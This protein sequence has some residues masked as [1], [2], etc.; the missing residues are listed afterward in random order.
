MWRLVLLL[1][2]GFV[3]SLFFPGEIL[4]LY[5]ILGFIL[6]PVRHWKN[7][8]L[9]ILSFI[10]MLQPV[11]WIKV[12]CGWLS[13]D[14]APRQMIFSLGDV[15]PQLGGD[16]WWEMVK[17]NFTIG[18]LASLNWAWC[19]GRVFQTCALF[20]L[21]LWI[22]RMGYFDSS[23]ETALGRSR[24]FWTY[25]LCFSLPLAVAF[26]FVKAFVF[27]LVSQ[28]LMLDSL[29]TIL[30]SWY[31]FCFMLTM[32]SAFL[33]LYWMGKGK[34]QKILVPYG[35]MSLTDYIMQSVIGSFL[36]FG[37][38]L[39]LHQYCGT[40]VSLLVGI[41][42]FLLQLAFSHWWFRHFKRGPLETLW[43][44]LTWLGRTVR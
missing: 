43:H 17:M 8:S 23:S 33:L 1:G 12:V 40:T 26:Y 42:F 34:I 7:R 3:N 30:N 36:Y 19:Y 39:A 24:S 25:V 11:E 18:Q 22:G 27:A 41:V 29:K 28:P 14:Y 6:V 21:G 2:F 9:L 44:K 35:R 16:S 31:N 4:V 5:A 32:V 10:L 15:Y 37:Y 20:V 13:P 38:G